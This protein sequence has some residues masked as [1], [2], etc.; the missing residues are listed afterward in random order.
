MKR[1][2]KFEGL[3]VRQVLTSPE[4]DDALTQYIS[5]SLS[6]SSENEWVDYQYSIYDA[7]YCCGSTDPN[8]SFSKY[9]TD[10]LFSQLASYLKIV[11]KEGLS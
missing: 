10:Q 9:L 8:I 5:K 11:C 1:N 4:F 7:I 2:V 6:Y 3:I